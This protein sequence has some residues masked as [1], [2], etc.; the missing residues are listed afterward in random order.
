MLSEQSKKI[1]FRSVD[2]SLAFYK[3]MHAPRPH[4]GMDIYAD[5]FKHDGIVLVQNNGL[6]NKGIP[7]R[8]DHFVLVLC[9]EGEALRRINQY[10]FP[11]TRHTFHVMRPGD[12]HSFTK[13]SHDF[14]IRILLFERRVLERIGLSPDQIDSLLSLNP[15]CE[16]HG[17]LT[18]DEFLNW[19]R[20]IE[21]LTGELKLDHP[22]QVQIL[23]GVILQ[24]WGWVRRG[25]TKQ[26]SVKKR[27]SKGFH[28]YTDFRGLVERNFNELKSVKDYAVMLNVTAKHLSETV[29]ELSNS[30]ALYYIHLR[31]LHE[32]E[33]L[34]AYTD[35]SVSE[36]CYDLNFDTVSH[37]GRFFKSKKGM[38]P[39]EYRDSLK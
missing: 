25:V 33:Y 14:D 18:I 7:M 34:L 39:S 26:L 11:V 37:F 32:A 30:T 27:R 35:S 4:F 29:K 38:T 12:I 10:Q 13:A 28:L 20:T 3:T 15:A 17:S 36:I 5:D 23:S 6:G 22:A 1:P 21:V 9:I 2:E 8:C 31:I 24:I 16:P 19:R